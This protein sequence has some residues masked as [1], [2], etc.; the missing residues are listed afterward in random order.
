MVLGRRVHGPG[1][2]H[3]LGVAATNFIDPGLVMLAYMVL[4]NHLY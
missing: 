2:I 4:I 1:R 3:V